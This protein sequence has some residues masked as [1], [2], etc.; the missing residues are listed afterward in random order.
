MVVTRVGGLPEII[1]H[2]KEGYVVEVKVK[3]I[4]D[5]IVD[6]YENKK[7]SAMVAAVK[8]GK[9]RFSWLNMVKGI[10]NLYNQI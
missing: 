8:E 6:Y 10:K 2:Q 4:A 1:A 3:A 7:A 5:A 9:K